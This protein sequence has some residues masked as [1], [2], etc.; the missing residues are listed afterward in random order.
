MYLYIYIYP[1]LISCL[2]HSRCLSVAI[3]SGYIFL[4]LV[5]M[6]HYLIGMM[7]R[8]RLD[9]CGSGE[10]CGVNNLGGGVL[11]RGFQFLELLTDC[12]LLKTV[13][14]ACSEV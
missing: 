9:L 3:F 7:G 14:A 11:K 6:P 4:L 1:L 13:S 12:W 2:L 10:K 5:N 8:F